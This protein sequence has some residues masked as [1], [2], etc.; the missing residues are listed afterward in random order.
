MI[1]VVQ[2][3]SDLLGIHSDD[4]YQMEKQMI[5]GRWSDLFTKYLTSLKKVIERKKQSISVDRIS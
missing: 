3:H 5:D 4:I 2:F 1:W